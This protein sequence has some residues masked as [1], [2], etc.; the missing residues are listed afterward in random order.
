MTVAEI[1]ALFE[2]NAWANERTLDAC[3]VLTPEQFTQP[4]GSS[5]PSVRDTLAHVLGAEWVWFERWHGRFPSF[6]RPEDIPSDLPGLRAQWE[7]NGRAL[8]DFARTRT[9]DHLNT[10]HE[11]RTFDGT[12]YTHALWQ[13]MQHLVNHGTYHRGQVATF[14]RQMGQKAAPTDL[15]RYYRERA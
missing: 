8:V 7:V 1:R 9:Q 2:Y 3:A 6:P 14:L 15:I 5:F 10:I 11:I 13:M 4:N 12:A